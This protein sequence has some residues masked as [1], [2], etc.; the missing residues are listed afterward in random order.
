M[1]SDQF[2]HWYVYFNVS[3]VLL[4]S[5]SAREASTMANEQDTMRKEI[6]QLKQQIAELGSVKSDNMV[7]TYAVLFSEN[8]A[9]RTRVDAAENELKNAQKLNITC[10][11]EIGELSEELLTLK[12]ELKE[13]PEHLMSEIATLRLE[14]AALVDKYELELATMRRKCNQLTG[15]LG[16]IIGKQRM[17]IRENAEK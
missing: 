16:G 12:Q 1:C 7:G 10:A 11:N 2:V 13:S 6:D 9:L 5:T 4:V 15:H 14:K 3:F 17:K 8:L